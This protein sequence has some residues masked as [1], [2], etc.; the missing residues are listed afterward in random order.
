MKLESLVCTTCGGMVDRESLTCKMCG[1]Q[2]RR[3]ARTG[4]LVERSI[5]YINLNCEVVMP[6]YIVESDPARAMEMTLHQVAE[7]LATRILPLM[8]WRQSYDLKDKS[9][10]TMGRIKV[11]KKAET[12]RITEMYRLSMP[13]GGIGEDYE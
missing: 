9:Y 5:P 13:F 2:Y 11:G 1:V 6:D 10:R 3:D 4:M 12:D 7:Q 8:E